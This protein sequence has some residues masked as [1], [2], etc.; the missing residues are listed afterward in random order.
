MKIFLTGITALPRIGGALALGL[1]AVCAG[2]AAPVAFAQGAPC[3]AL[4]GRSIEPALIGLP[5]GP[6]GIAS[7]AIERLPVSPAATEPTVAYCKVL[8]E[9]A[10]RDP[11]A[12]PIRFEVNLPE[13]WN[14][15]AVQYGGGGFNGVLMVPPDRHLGRRSSLLAANWPAQ[16]PTRRQSQD[17]FSHSLDPYR[18]F[19]RARTT[20]AAVKTGN[21]PLESVH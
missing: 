15:K 18:P 11:A 2:P 7:A 3:A 13:V 8:G 20:L 16:E 9:I 14:G 5:S 10:P 6:A 17:R 21:Q 12:P 4:A 1:A 19:N